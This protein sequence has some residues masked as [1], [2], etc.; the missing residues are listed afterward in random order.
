MEANYTDYYLNNI[1]T[2]AKSN[3]FLRFNFL[4]TGGTIKNLGYASGLFS[5][6]IVPRI[7]N[8][9]EDSGKAY[10]S[11]NYVKIPE[12]TGSGFFDI[13]NCT[14]IF[15]YEKLKIGSHTF[16]SNIIREN[17]TEYDADENS[18]PTNIYKGFEFG[19]TANNNLYFEYFNQNGPNVF[20]QNKTL[21]DKSA[22]FLTLLNNSINFG[23]FDFITQN[24][25]SDNVA[26]NSSYIFNPKNLYIGYNPDSYGLYN[27]NTP[28][29]GKMADFMISSPK[30]FSS[31]IIE[32]QKGFSYEYTPGYEVVTS[33]LF[34]G[35]TGSLF[36]I[37]G[38]GYIITGYQKTA[39]GVITDNW[40][41]ETMGY[42][43]SP[44]YG[45]E[46]LYGNLDLTGSYWVYNT[47]ISGSII[48]T[49]GNSFL[50]F[51]KKVIKF[52]SKKDNDDFIEL[53]LNTGNSEVLN[54]KNIPLF[55]DN[56]SSSFLR[57]NFR[58]D[59]KHISVFANGQLQLSGLI[60]GIPPQYNQDII[61]II[62]NDYGFEDARLIF[63]N[64]YRNQS[65][66]SIFIDLKTG[67]AIEIKNF[68][69]TKEL[70]DHLFINHRIP[71]KWRGAWKYWNFNS[72]SSSMNLEAHL[73][74]IEENSNYNLFFNGQKLIEG[75]DYPYDGLTGNLLIVSRD[76]D[77]NNITS[78][79][80]SI[81][82]DNNFYDQT[83][84]IYV[85][86]IRQT[87]NEDYIE[88]GKFDLNTGALFLE[89]Q[90][91]FIYNN[92]EL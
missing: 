17:S 46:L 62:N 41:F 27:N 2:E 58:I 68:V 73:N 90:P 54:K 67:D 80:S 86:G 45:E 29:V 9:W 39:T 72:T 81:L 19:V 23:Y 91:D 88:L 82:L 71:Y 55:F 31:Q 25:I 49:Y 48:Q 70:V 10:F 63:Y 69:Y 59:D 42:S 21:A 38:T 50:S 61:R 75:I 12:I 8:F 22:V 65:F 66:D 84:E 85:N 15:N 32:L 87:F 6:E 24:I 64:L 78:G 5:G 52:N 1:D 44:L 57:K 79:M 60:S 74:L 92:T 77:Y 16:I 35:I 30:L 11:G 3:I 53:G 40:G 13:K 51:C 28:F 76:Y 37:T 20:V 43:L 33:G 89:N 14:F 4:E 7:N 18:Y 47:G 34:T 36:T 26:I 56:Y 83:S